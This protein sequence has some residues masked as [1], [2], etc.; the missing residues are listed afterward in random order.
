MQQEKR[1][2]RI[3]YVFQDEYPWDIRVDKFVN[4]LADAG[5][6]VTLLSRNRRGLPRREQ[7]RAGVAIFRSPVGWTPLDRALA[8]FPAFFSPWWL[9][10][11]V[12]TVRSERVDLIVVR[13][14]PLA[15]AAIY[16]RNATRCPVLM[17]MAENYP[18]MI[19]ANWDFYG[20]KPWDY[21]V[22]N[23]ALLR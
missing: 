5:H 16:A 2:L 15:A 8:G 14:L 13:D 11:L 1:R 19:Q 4:S 6:R 17:D 7:L 20:P 12:Q 23:P 9:N 21:A 22:R 18:A 10:A 3:C